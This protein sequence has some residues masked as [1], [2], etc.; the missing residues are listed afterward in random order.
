MIKT[1]IIQAVAAAGAVLL[2]AKL[3]PAVRVRRTQTAIVVAAVFAILNLLFGWLLIRPTVV[4]LMGRYAAAKVN[5]QAVFTAMNP[6]A[7]PHADSAGTAT[8]S[9]RAPSTRP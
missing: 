2:A 3:I 1:F 6:A 8:R 9:R 4:H 7:D 5:R